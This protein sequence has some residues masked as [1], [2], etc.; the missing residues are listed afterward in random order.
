RTLGW[1]RISFLLDGR[2]T[3]LSIDGE[4]VMVNERLRR[5]DS[6]MLGS[7]W[8]AS[9]GWYD[10]LTIEPRDLSDA[11][12]AAIDAADRAER[13]AAR[14]ARIDALTADRSRLGGELKAAT[15]GHLGA[16]TP[17]AEEYHRRLSRYVRYHQPGMRDFAGEP[18]LRFHKSDNSQEHAVRQNATTALCYATLLLEPGRYDAQLAGVPL[19]TV[20][21]EAKAL[22][23]YLSYTHVA[24][25]WPTGDGK[26]WGN[27]WQSALWMRYAGHAAWLMWDKLDPDLQAAV[28]RMVVQEADR[29]IPRPPDSGIRFDTKAEE[30]AWNALAPALA[31]CMFPDH[32]HAAQRQERAIVYL[33]NSFPREA[34]RTLARVIDGKPARDRITAACI[35]PD[36]T[37]ENHGRVHPDYLGCIG[38]ME[39]NALVYLPVG[40][41][42]P[43][44]TFF[45][46][47]ECYSVLQRLWSPN[48]SAYYIN[49]QDWWPHRH[50]SPLSVAGMHAVVRN[51][52]GAAFVARSA[53]AATAKMH[54]RFDDGR[55]WAREEVAYP[56]AEEE[57][58]AR[59]AEL[60][61][62]HRLAGDGP[63]PATAAA[64]QAQQRGVFVSEPGG[65]AVQRLAGKTAS[66]SWA[67]GAMGLVWPAGD[68]DTWFTSPSERGLV[69]RI[70]VA[71]QPDDRPVTKA[72]AVQVKGDALAVTAQIDRC[73]GTVRQE[74]A[75]VSL[76]DAP[77]I[78][79][80][81][82]TAR[83]AVTVDSVD[84]GL[85]PILNEPM[86]NARPNHRRLE[87]AGG[88]VDIVGVSADPARTL[89]LPGAWACLDGRL[90]VVSSRAG[91]VY[92]D[93]NRW[94]GARLEETLIANHRVKP[95]AFE[96]GQ[97]ISE[98]A[99]VL[100]PG[101]DAKATA[102]APVT[103]VPGAGLGARFGAVTVTADVGKG[104][105]GW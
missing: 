83:K 6:I 49:G 59:Y 47:P 18:G 90:G 54:A 102:A 45:N 7:P 21:G 26:P 97:V 14:Q 12:L 29:F 35:W 64:W 76:P 99:V 40:R 48:G 86:P 70:A 33:I 22:L 84:T 43:E 24:N 50:D 3:A 98:V 4:Q 5:L 69:G 57:M 88:Q 10:D 20:E 101:A 34:D 53:L 81:R 27:H 2:R 89:D 56:N 55:L 105:V 96:P 93:N 100:L 31:T 67:N 38:L 82:L 71:G 44:S 91:L 60:Y 73:G 36:F 17:L 16:T 68:D 62:L 11:E 42:I 23:R 28:A 30:N 19:S 78:Y 94:Q 63:P 72:H 46:V 13:A 37:L 77:V 75:F 25:G 65:F 39:W 1:H 32:P 51:D 80:E 66:F 15:Y 103:W 92:Q 61:L 79:L 52:A 58:A 8:D 85:V 9:T 41:P 104:E 74:I 87:H 95:G